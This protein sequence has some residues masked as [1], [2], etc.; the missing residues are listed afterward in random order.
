MADLCAVVELHLQGIP[1]KEVL[2][3]RT[4]KNLGLILN[5]PG[6][7]RNWKDV[8]DRLGKNLMEIEGHYTHQIGEGPGYSLLKD[9]MVINGGTI[10]RL[11]QIFKELELMSCLEEMEKDVQGIVGL[12]WSP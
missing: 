11:C 12:K 4:L 5:T 6:S 7:L 10:S 2:P 8:A 9:W 3:Y 1:A